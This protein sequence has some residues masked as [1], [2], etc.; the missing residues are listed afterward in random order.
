MKRK[1]LFVMN[2]L[3]C[4]GAEKA[5]I[6]LLETIDY[7][8]VDV[9]L[10][11][12][13]HEGLFVQNIPKQVR[14]LAEP[15]AY[16]LFDMP[17]KLALLQCIK[18]GRL[19]LIIPRLLAGYVFKQESH[20]AVCEQRVWRFLSKSFKPLATQYDAA[21]GY[22]EKNPIYYCIEKVS[23]AKKIG[24]I[25]NDYVKLGM[26]PEYD[27]DYF[28]QLDHIMT[29][30]EE[31]AH[32]LKAQFPAF[33]HKVEVMYNIVSPRV[34]HHL[35]EDQ[36]MEGSDGV[37]LVSVGRLNPQKGFDLAIEACK[38]LI[39]QGYRLTWTVIGEGSQRAELEALIA[40]YGL[41][42]VFKLIGIRDNPYPYVKAA[43]IYVQPSRFEGKSIAIDEAKI[44]HKPIVLT[45]F[46]TAK[47]QITHE[48]NGLIVEMTPAA[49]AEGIKRFIEDQALRY[50]VSKQLASEQL[51]TEVEIE[52]IYAMV[53]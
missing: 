33:S 51:G 22:L 18:S 9:D 48:R 24:F 46:T 30:S 26:N 3:H 4:G 27:K 23:A 5:L 38:L 49:V 14:L 16:K 45:H 44:L 36:A 35:A 52:K 12:F 31:C 50:Q 20:P 17:I 10:F 19:D 47:D 28:E 2:N 34:I 25:H 39:D 11:L 21:I 7:E 37:Q 13:K 8:R 1:L 32:V 29:V 6:S 53:M 42:D 41:K 40:K 15:Q 43:D